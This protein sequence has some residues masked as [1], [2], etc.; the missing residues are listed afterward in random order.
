MPSDITSYVPSWITPATG[1]STNASAA[2]DHSVIRLFWNESPY[3]LT[4][5]AREVLLN[6]DSAN[7]YPDLRQTRLREAIGT[8]IGV[9]A[10]R[11]VPGAGLDDVLNTVA[12]LF[13]EPDDEVIIADPTFGV[14]RSLFALHG[15]SIRNVPLGTAPGFELDS[16]GIIDAVS[17]KTKMIVLCNPNNPTG[18]VIPRERIEKIVENVTCPVIIDEAYAEFSEVNHVDLTDRFDHVVVLRTMSK[19]AGLAGMRV[20]YGIFPD[21]LMPYARRVMPS[22][23]NISLLAAEVAIACLEDLDNVMVNRDRII[24][25][26]TRV[27]EALNGI[28]GLTAYPSATNFILF[29]TPLAD[30]TPIL[31]ALAERGVMI[32]RLGNEGL[33]NTLRVSIGSPDENTAFLDALES[34]MADIRKASA[35]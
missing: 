17:D 19:F 33:E 24:A 26:R 5:K 6:F 3:P 13:L 2:S 14:Y 10:D 31:D 20:G 11:V 8:Y 16:E 35:V 32:R 7:R 18:N 34:V 22:F 23:C 29:A 9:D 15:A 1:Y 27:F 4:E 21:A 28:G 12:T 25:E 30:S